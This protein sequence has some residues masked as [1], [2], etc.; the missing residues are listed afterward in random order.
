MAKKQ[1]KKKEEKVPEKF[2]APKLFGIS[3]KRADELFNTWRHAKLDNDTWQGVWKQTVKD[4]NLSG[5]AEFAYLGY[6]FGR[7]YEKHDNPLEG[8]GDLLGL[9]SKAK[10]IAINGNDMPDELKK[11]L[12]DH[13][14]GK[15]NH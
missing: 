14:S 13:L 3:D 4:G 9:L 2:S 10:G 7:L 12:I 5:E 11:H 8:L 1:A 6:V 15:H